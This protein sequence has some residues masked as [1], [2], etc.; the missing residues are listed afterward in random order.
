[1][2]HEQIIE[3]AQKR[4]EM[5]TSQSRDIYRIA[6]RDGAEWADES[7]EEFLPKDT[8]YLTI[9]RDKNYKVEKKFKAWLTNFVG[10]DKCCL[11]KDGDD[12][13]VYVLD[14]DACME[15]DYQILDDHP[16]FT[17]LIILKIA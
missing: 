4:S 10:T 14:P 12:G 16:S 11:A 6:F 9:R 7:R 3:Q 1:M 15:N 17:H 13:N 8:F 5:C 2:R